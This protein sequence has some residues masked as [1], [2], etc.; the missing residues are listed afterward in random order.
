MALSKRIQKELRD[1]EH[2][3]PSNCSAGPVRDDLNHW[4]A[5][6]I[7]PDGSPYAGGIFRL[8]IHFPADYPFKPPKIVFLNRVFHPNINRNGAICLD[9]LKDQWSPAL[10]ISRV[11]L[12]ISSLLTDPNPNDP[13]DGESA[14]L[15]KTNRAKFD[16]VAREYT[17]RYAN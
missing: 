9:I 2:D 17:A 14:H 3:P 10:T 6:I 12:S 1:F 4:Q 5:T 16:Q 8:D 11:L 13:L 15:Y 7:G